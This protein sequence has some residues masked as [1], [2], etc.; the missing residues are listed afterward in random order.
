[1][2]QSVNNTD[3]GTT[4]ADPSKLIAVQRADLIVRSVTVDSFQGIRLPSQTQ[5]KFEETGKAVQQLLKEG[6]SALADPTPVASLLERFKDHMRTLEG[7]SD[8]TEFLR[9]EQ[10]S[11]AALKNV[12]EENVDSCLAVFRTD[13]GA[14]YYMD[15]FGYTVKITQEV[16]GELAWRC[17]HKVIFSATPSEI[18]GEYRSG[19]EREPMSKGIF[20]IEDSGG[21]VAVRGYENEYY[22]GGD[23]HV[24]SAFAGAK[25]SEIV[26]AD[27]D[28]IE[29]TFHANSRIDSWIFSRRDLTL[30]CQREGLSPFEMA[31]VEGFFNRYLELFC[32]LSVDLPRLESLLE[33]GLPE[34]VRSNEIFQAALD[35]V[36]SDLV[37]IHKCF[38]FSERFSSYFDR[39]VPDFPPEEDRVGMIKEI[40]SRPLDREDST[41]ELFAE[42]LNLESSHVVSQVL[43]DRDILGRLISVV[44]VGFSQG[45]AEAAVTAARA[46]SHDAHQFREACNHSRYI[47]LAL[48]FVA[49]D[50]NTMKACIA[51]VSSPAKPAIEDSVL[52][53]NQEHARALSKLF[54]QYS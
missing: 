25:I 5:K 24:Q 44:D 21:F 39:P 11:I 48:P 36:N 2:D 32:Q 20:P 6:L 12:L 38:D 34:K 17:F 13:D 15:E 35:R 52:Q 46:I 30:L 28:T 27:D 43:S 31:Q 50:T 51:A 49:L 3:G 40:G 7:F 8:Q 22:I 47:A 4:K 10:L 9:E 29:K 33:I 54:E 26:K 41:L 1:M 23:P 16:T 42:R 18:S 37:L 19:G 14:S 45:R 53:R